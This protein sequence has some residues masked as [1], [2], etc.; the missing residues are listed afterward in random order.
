MKPFL[1]IALLLLPGV[2]FVGC[3]VTTKTVADR[4]VL[5]DLQAQAGRKL[6]PLIDEFAKRNRLVPDK[7][8]PINPRYQRKL[9]DE[10]IEEISYT[11]GMGKF[12][13]ELSLFRYRETGKE[14]L[15]AFDKFIDEEVVPQYG[16]TNCRA[17]PGY[18]MPEVYR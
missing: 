13:A 17:V 7:S 18:E 4:C 11:I 9:D 5:V 3:D 14:I 10:L 8:H 6:I 15:E 1:S 16:V 12:G 2:A